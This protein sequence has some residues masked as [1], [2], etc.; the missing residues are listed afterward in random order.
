MLHRVPFSFLH[1]STSSLSEW[2]RNWRQEL[3]FYVQDRRNLFLLC[4]P[5]RIPVCKLFLY[6]LAF[7][8]WASRNHNV[9]PFCVVWQYRPEF[10]RGRWDH[11]FTGP[12]E[13]PFTGRFSNSWTRFRAAAYE[14]ILVPRDSIVFLLWFP[15]ICLWSNYEVQERSR[16]FQQCYLYQTELSSACYHAACLRCQTVKISWHSLLDYFLKFGIKIPAF[17]FVKITSFGS[18]AIRHPRRFQ[19]TGSS[20]ISLFQIKLICCE[21]GESLSINTRKNLHRGLFSKPPALC[22]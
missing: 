10:E 20:V 4:D 15:P 17:I 13:L 16:P 6:L 19:A 21:E 3:D 11:P 14:P 1:L 18:V 8:S 12:D 7:G 2:I 5:L 9:H 22:L